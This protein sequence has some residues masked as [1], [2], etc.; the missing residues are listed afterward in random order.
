MGCFD[1]ETTKEEHDDEYAGKCEGCG[2]DIDK[3]GYCIELDNCSYS[4]LECK[5]CDYR[6]CDQ[7]CQVYNEN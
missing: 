1:C 4:P 7:S 5:I 2:A 3:D 6:P